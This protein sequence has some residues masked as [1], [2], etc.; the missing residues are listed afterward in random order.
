MDYTYFLLIRSFP[1]NKRYEHN[2]VDEDPTSLSDA[3]YLLHESSFVSYVVDFFEKTDQKIISIDDISRYNL[4]I[5]RANI[6]R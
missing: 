1:W 2:V 4:T 6:S 5:N 3:S